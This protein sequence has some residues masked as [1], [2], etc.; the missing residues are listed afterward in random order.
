MA[1]TNTLSNE[2]GLFR[3][4]LPDLLHSSWRLLPVAFADDAGTCLCGWLLVLL[5]GGA[6]PAAQAVKG[7]ELVT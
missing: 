4:L 1:L 3:L 5:L 2:R 6:L 7:Q